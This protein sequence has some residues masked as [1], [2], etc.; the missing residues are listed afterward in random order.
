MTVHDR[1]AFIIGGTGQIGRA[2]AARLTTAG[3][4]VTLGHRRARPDATHPD[5]VTSVQVDRA[6]TEALLKALD[7][8]DLVVDTVAFAPHHGAQ[9]ARLAGRVGSLVVIST[10]AVYQAPGLPVPIPESWPTVERDAHDYPAGKAALE[11]HLLATPGLPV[12]ILRTGVLHGPYGTSLDHW[13]FIKRALDKRPHVVIA[14]DGRSRFPTTAVANVAEL[15]CLCAQR[16]AARVLNIAD[17]PLTVA[18]IG[19]R[20]FAVMGHE[21][22]I[23]TFEGPSRPDG[24]GFHPWNVPEPIVFSMDRARAELGYRH[25]VSYDDALRADIGWAVPA[26]S[27]AEAAGGGWQDVF[28]DLVARHGPDVWFPYAAE[29][30][31]VTG[32]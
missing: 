25:A 12:S 7:G 2:T 3:Y 9:L 10:G 8:H 28:P 29:D 4:A 1:R 14:Q 11:R 24:L 26:V 15:I 23:I 19:A 21:A 17:D 6:D 22:E 20:V 5:G 18:E 13:S 30:A 32:G 31:Y 16:P 27:E